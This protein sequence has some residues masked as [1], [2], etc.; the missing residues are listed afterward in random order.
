MDIYQLKTFVTVAREASITRAS[1]VL[2][3]SQPAVSAHIKAMED[4]L[5][6]SLFNRTPRGMTL[7]ADGQRLLAKAERTLA[8]H[9]EL[10]AEATRSKGELTG[11]LRLGAGTNSSNEA[12]GRL[13]T[14]LAER[15]PGVDV[16]LKHR[17]SKEILAGIRNGSLDAGFYN[18]PGK[19]APDLAVTEVAQFTIHLVAAP[20]LV[21]A[22]APPDWKAIAE[23]SWIYPTES[24]CCSH[25]AEKLFSS[26]RFKPKRI[27]GA[28]RQDVIRT[29]VASG[30]GVGLLHADTA[31]E[32]QRRG[33]V[34]LLYEAET[35]VRVLFAH[36]A[37]RAEEPLLV[38]ASNIMREVSRD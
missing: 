20:G 13:L 4:A 31:R 22:S 1:E 30:I 19:A 38:A 11:R 26:H 21:A 7:T 36:L 2:H 24:A 37:S 23:L 3:L 9:Q 5:G 16:E 8:A 17:T 34:E 6:L 35:R 33:E 25:T 10:L 12:I 28:D 15:C 32:A 27:I 18:E 29:L 14:V